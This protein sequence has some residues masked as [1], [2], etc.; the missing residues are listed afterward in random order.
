M[1]QQLLQQAMALHQAG[2][3]GEAEQLYQQVLAASPGDYAA[4]HLMGLLRL[5]QNRLPEALTFMQAALK[6]QPGAPETLANYGIALS[7]LGRQ[8]E[9][10]AA[11]DGVVRARPDDSK[12]WSNRGSIRHRLGRTEEALADFER[13]LALDGGNLDALNNR[14]LSLQALRRPVEAL[15]SFDA[16][17]VRAPDYPEGR[18]NRGLVLR[19]LGRTEEALAEFD[20][21]VAAQPDHAGAWVNRAALLWRLEKLDEALES[22]GRALAI[23]PDLL[24]ALESRANLLWTRKQAL[25]PAIAD[26]ERAASIAPDHAYLR[27]ALLHLKM[28][29]GDWRNFAA[30][31]AALDAAVR[32]GKPAV[33]PY[34][35][36]GLSDSPADLLTCARIYTAREYPA[37]ARRMAIGP[38]KP[39]RIRIGYVCG[40]FRAQATMYL[41]A[42]L[43][44]QH[45]RSR[46]E[47]I[48][49]DNGRD[50]G[51]AMRARVMASFDKFI[52]IA[53]LS[54]AD[55][56][57]VIR[58][59]EVDILVNLNGYFGSMRMGVFALSPAPIQ[60]NYLGFP[61]TLG[62]DYMDYI[63]ADGT[64]IPDGE[65]RFFAEKVV[66]LPGSYQINDSKR[67]VVG[68]TRRA[69]HG[70]PENA[71]VFCHFNYG[72]KILPD[73]FALWL[74]LLKQTPGSV[75][76]LLS[77]D[78]LLT[79]NL[80]A[81][82]G[83]Q[84][85]D[86][87]R[88]IFAPPLPLEA[89]LA[90][91]ALGDLFLDSLPYNAHTTASDALWAGLPLLTCRGA[92][93]AGRVAAS[94]L[95]AMALPELVTENLADYESL[96]LTLAREPALLKIYRDRLL[97]NWRSA[98]L[99]DTI[100]TTRHIEAAYDAMMERRGE[101]PQGFAVSL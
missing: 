101:A 55:A 77:G 46:F 97:E 8:E 12:A 71:F 64:V 48:A 88:L 96:A 44:E 51:S 98:P 90:R 18:N 86:P 6:V 85:V 81:E 41:A 78:P 36:Q 76:W 14:G 11:L 82:A 60:V 7:G 45:D 30:D 100:R 65:D 95:Q 92:A 22:Y 27:G 62:A 17:L 58:A 72:Y 20:N 5:M 68:A 15:A 91:M 61:G 21:V 59:E 69:E 39:G 37:A 43:F 10:L 13:A 47:I 42:G 3:L 89:H 16:M 67:T 38:R 49:F 29:A 75:L 33:L 70:L 80:K 40:E 4:L 31:K 74:R 54:D 9:A 35:Y 84:A 23:N 25:A 57:A 26:L 66:R 63:I 94:L 53:Q 50:D 99:F 24:E 19:A 56:A 52:S 79:Q 73:H 28:H 2:R 32:A 34:V 1:S 83:R 93:F 87:Q